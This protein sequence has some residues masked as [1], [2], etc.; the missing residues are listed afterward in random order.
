MKLKTLAE[1]REERGEPVHGWVLIAT[2]ALPA[3]KAKAD[4]LAQQLLETVDSALSKLE[5]SSEGRL[6]V[7]GIQMRMESFE[8]Y[9]AWELPNAS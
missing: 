3:D 2:G 9:Q 8:A 1:I 5:T 4:A 7:G 6:E